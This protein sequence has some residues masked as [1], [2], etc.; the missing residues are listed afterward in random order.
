MKKKYSQCRS[1]AM[2]AGFV[3]LFALAA[4]S[5]LAA[6][7]GMVEM[8]TD[9]AKEKG[10]IG[11]ASFD[12]QGK[13]ML[14][15]DYR[16]WVFVGAPVTPNDMNGG[17]AAFPEFH[18]VYIDPGSF[19][20]YQETGKFRDGTVIVKE[21]ATVG[22]K[23][24]ASGNG[25]FPGEFNGLAVAVKSSSRFADEPGNWGYFNFGGEGGKLKESARAQETA[26]C[27]PCH[28]KNAA[29]D[30]VFTQYYPVLR[31]ARAK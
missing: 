1:A 6:E 27:S 22:G 13:L 12:P 28:Q 9:V 25:Y 30:L 11:A 2:I 26:A 3:V 5:A 29:Q 23:K 20:L 17:K 10:M 7:K 8:I 14:P 31:A 24:G 19:K 4:A 16:R 21:L 15:K 18:H